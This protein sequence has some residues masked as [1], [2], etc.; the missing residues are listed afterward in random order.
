MGC[1]VNWLSD[2]QRLHTYSIIFKEVTSPQKTFGWQR[3]W[4]TF[5]QK[6]GQYISNLHNGAASYVS[7]S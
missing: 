1:L 3:S 6:I 4:W 7:L 2:E 5:S